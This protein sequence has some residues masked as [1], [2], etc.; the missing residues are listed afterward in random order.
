[1]SRVKRGTTGHARHKKTIDR[2]SG[3]RGRSKSSFRVAIVIA[4]TAN[5]PSVPFGSN[6]SMPAPAN[7]G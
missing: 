5:G 6:G 7:T 4:V 2:A 1:M 3:Y